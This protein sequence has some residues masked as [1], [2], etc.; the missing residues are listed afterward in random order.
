MFQ[1]NENLEDY[2]DRNLTLD[3]I[4]YADKYWEANCNFSAKQNQASSNTSQADSS[5][6]EETGKLICCICNAEHPNFLSLEEH[7]NDC[8]ENCHMYDA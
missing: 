4:D 8:F 7:V 3:D 1:N 2:I 6:K 5:N